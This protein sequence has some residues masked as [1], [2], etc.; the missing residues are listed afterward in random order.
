MKKLL[1]KWYFK[2]FITY[3]ILERTCVDYSTADK[4]V[5]N[6]KGKPSHEHWV[7]DTDFEDKN[8]EFGIVY[9]CRK[10]RILE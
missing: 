8:R 9:L 2:I 7:I 4:M 3:E 10:K 5:L 6:Y 1:R